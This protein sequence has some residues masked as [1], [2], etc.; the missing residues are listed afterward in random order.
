MNKRLGYSKEM[1]ERAVCLVLTSEYEHPSGWAVTQSIVS[2]IGFTPETLRTW[3]N[4]IEV[5]SGTTS[6]VTSD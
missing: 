5:D 2:K 4:K 6:G 1:R 3:I